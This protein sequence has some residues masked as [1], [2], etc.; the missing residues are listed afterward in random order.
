MHAPARPPPPVHIPVDRVVYPVGLLV[1]L[2]VR[3]ARKEAVFVVWI[4]ELLCIDLG[5]L[6]SSGLR[7]PVRSVEFK[8][9]TRLLKRTLRLQQMDLLW[10]V[11]YLS[12]S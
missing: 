1:V 2:F 7:L 10:R 12:E 8:E 5:F 4:L 3:R 6:A 11:R 9:Y